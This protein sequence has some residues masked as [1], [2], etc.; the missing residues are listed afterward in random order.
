MLVVAVL[1]FW[2]NSA[3]AAEIT[4]ALEPIYERPGGTSM[5]E[6][7]LLKVHF[8]D[9]GGGDAI[10]ID[11]PTDKKILIDGG[12]TWK[13]RIDAK[14]EYD[15]YLD[16]F[17]GDDVIDLIVIS[18][19]DYDHFG[20]LS[21]VLKNY[22]VQQVWASGYDSDDLS[23]SWRDLDEQLRNDND[24]LYLSPLGSYFGL[25]SSFRF[26]DADTYD[27]SDDTV[28]TLINTQQ[29]IPKQ[30][31]GN[32]GRRLSESQQR[33]S[34]S[35]VLRLDYGKTSFLFTEDVNG[36]EKYSPKDSHDDQE[37]FMVDNNNNPNNVL[38]GLLDVDVLKVA[39]HGTDGSSSLKF[40]KAAKPEWAVITAGFPHGHPH[41]G[42]LDR[43]KSSEVGLD[44]MHILR[45][46]DGDDDHANSANEE[47]LGDDTYVFTLDPA[48]IVRIE[49]WNIKVQ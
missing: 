26:D 24:T 28:L 49:K 22:V 41:Q 32:S 13:E 20:A 38:H 10:L 2:A 40:L 19:P 34:A 5:D 12:F 17:L 44:G 45:T 23:G 35:V 7:K 42:V 25:G 21:D 37:K 31:Y 1:G 8:I 29:W 14:K 11:T 18:H 9:V 30:A 39:H 6:D 43:L 33:N 46:D 15:A 3:Q 16:E 48:G 4:R 47:N 36:R 27:Q